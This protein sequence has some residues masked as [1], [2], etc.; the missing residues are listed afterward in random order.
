M[1]T[2]ISSTLA[3]LFAAILM[4]GMIV[5]GIA[6]LFNGQVRQDATTLSLEGAAAAQEVA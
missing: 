2:R 6:V 1:N 3:A 4:N 5:G